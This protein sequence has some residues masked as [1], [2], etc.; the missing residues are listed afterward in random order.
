MTFLLVASPSLP[1]Y[2]KDGGWQLF[3]FSVSGAFLIIER[4]KLNN[5]KFLILLDSFTL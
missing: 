4:V 2:D 5:F 1:I 3:T